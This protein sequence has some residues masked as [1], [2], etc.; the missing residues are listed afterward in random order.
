MALIRPFKAYRPHPSV[1]EKIASLPYDVLSVEEARAITAE[2]PLS[3]LRVEKSEVDLPPGADSKSEEVFRKG[4]ENL[5][6]LIEHGLMIRDEKPCLYIYQQR[7][8]NHVQAGL[9]AGASVDEYQDGRIRKHELTRKDKEDERTR[10]VEVIGANTGPVF[11]TYRAVDSLDRVV[12]D[13]R[14]GKPVY[15]FTAEDGISHTLWVVSDARTIKAI[16]DEFAKITRIYVADGHHRS[17]AASRVREI[18]KAA[19]PK[20]TG[21]EQYNFFLSVIFPHNQ[22]RIMDYN[23][24][25]KDLAGMAEKDF[26]KKVGEKFAVE[27]TTEPKPREKKSFGMFLGGKWHI[28]RA[29]RGTFPADDPVESL[30]VAILQNN[31][32]G[33]ILGIKDPRTDKRIDFVGG[34]R[35]TK[36][37]ERRC[38]KDAKAA[39]AMHPTGIEDLMAVADAEKIMPPKS[40]WFEPKLRSGVIV[41]MLDE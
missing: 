9:V 40:T 21:D 24:V 19:N 15:N 29:K 41:K 14:G 3:F 2:N 28:L 6:R 36:E 1:I 39:F 7:M 22:M 32:L 20:H 33:P 35:G 5:K 8:G 25:V 31:L 12:E 13:I 4:A 17:A 26:L 37:L 18:R 30:D 38:A 23:R 34:I 11:L 16:E 10:H 27:P